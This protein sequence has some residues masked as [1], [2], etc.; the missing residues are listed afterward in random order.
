MEDVVADSQGFP[1]RSQDTLVLTS[2]IDHV[3]AKVWEGKVV[4]SLIVTYLN[5]ICDFNLSN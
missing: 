2:Y 4:I 1:S 5:F 3:A